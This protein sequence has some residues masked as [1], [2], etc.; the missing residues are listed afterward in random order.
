VLFEFNRNTVSIQFSI[1]PSRD[2][3]EL[4]VRRVA[5]FSPERV[6]SLD[7]PLNWPRL[8]DNGPAHALPGEIEAQ[9]QSVNFQGHPE[10]YSIA[11]KAVQIGHTES[12]LF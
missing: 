8:W 4:F 12:A 5:A 6:R 10:L 3:E 9:R 7:D 2:F 11:S 1:L